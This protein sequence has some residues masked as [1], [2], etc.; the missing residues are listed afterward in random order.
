MS[1]PRLDL[2]VE[3]FESGAVVY[4]PTA[5]PASG[6]PEQGR[7]MLLLTIRSSEATALQIQDLR[8]VFSGKGVYPTKTLPLNLTI[9]PSG[10]VAWSF[11]NPTDAVLF[12]M[13]PAPTG[14]RLEIRAAGFSEAAT[15]TF[16][17]RPHTAPT[18]TGAYLFPA[19]VSELRNEYWFA[20]ENHGVGSWGSQSFAYDLG[21][22]NAVGE[23]VTSGAD[24]TRN[25]HFRVWGKGIHAMADGVVRHALNDVPTNPKPLTGADWAQEFLEQKTA[26]WG[27]WLADNGFDP[28]LDEPHAGAGNHLYLQHGEE[29]VLYAHLQPGSIPNRLL[30]EGA[31]VEAGEL[32]GLA[33][34]SGNSSSPHLH[35]HAIRGNE[36]EVGPLRPLVF[37][38][39]SVLGSS[40]ISLSPRPWVQVVDGR[41][42]P[43]VSSYIWPS[44]PPPFERQG[45]DAAI[46]P[47]S[48]LLSNAVY[49]RLKLPNPPPL[50]VMLK[51]TE[52]IMVRA[53]AAERANALLKI[54]GAIG[55]LDSAAETIESLGD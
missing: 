3:P 25:E 1:K 7:L 37:A 42:L 53:S 12:P 48:L 45:E 16:R 50:S 38:P 26:V 31:P 20:N 24:G 19:L 39:I 36:A 23:W 22:Q 41:S 51:L 4:A 30:T 44:A 8:I 21:V 54:Q 52:N 27:K 2:T 6:Q 10:A 35:V 29:V 9:A 18:P 32:L 34:N 43:A 28:N 46:D 5:A 49:V 15:F 40:F 33:G 11:Q 13:L 14:I 55:A 17:L 47:L